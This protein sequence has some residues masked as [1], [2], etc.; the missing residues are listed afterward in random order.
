[1]FQMNDPYQR[2]EGLILRAI[3]Y[4]DFD[5]ILTLFTADAGL[6]KIMC[7]GSRS[8]R[9]KWRGLCQPLTRV[10]LV[11]REKQGEIFECRDITLVDS[12]DSLKQEFRHMEAA[13]D[14]LQALSFSQMP[15]KEAPQL[16]AS[17]IL[18]LKKI[19]LQ[20]D[21]WIPAICFRL[22][23]LK[24]EGLLTIPFVCHECHEP[25][26]S[27]AFCLQAEAHC[28]QHQMPAALHFASD[29]LLAVYQLASCRS[30]HELADLILPI[31]F[32]DK[33]C[34]F[35]QDCCSHK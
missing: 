17:L 25:L 16:Y 10:E 13:C 11:Y 19:P 14:L 2:T 21:P 26:L 34:R 20:A 29:E 5:Q 9:S 15:G 4:R 18:L 7:Y 12:H 6:L 35:F 32:K 30:L 1:M 3:S 8:Q 28:S 27:D 24:H 31:G 23:L 22:K 33:V